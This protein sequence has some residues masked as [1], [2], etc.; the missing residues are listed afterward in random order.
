MARRMT[1][2]LLLALNLLHF[3][4][5][6]ARAPASSRW[7]Q[8]QQSPPKVA[9]S[10]DSSRGWRAAIQHVERYWVEV[11]S[12]EKPSVVKAMFAH[13]SKEVEQSLKASF[14]TVFGTVFVV[15][16]VLLMYSLDA[17]AIVRS[18]RGFV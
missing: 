5:S 13:V 18:V 2:V 1:I 12:D 17:L 15:T 8:D 4:H 14:E 11:I 7:P 3:S 10:D 9:R 6:Q 16:C